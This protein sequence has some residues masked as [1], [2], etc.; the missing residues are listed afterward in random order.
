MPKETAVYTHGHHES[1]LRSH[2]WRTAANSAAYLLPELRSGQDV[3]DVGCGP[4]TITADLA[5]LV[6]PGTV[7]AVDTAEDVLDKARGAAEAAG[8]DSVRF[9]VADVHDLDFPDDSF[10]VVHAHQVLQHVG[11]PVRALRELRRVCRPGGVI[12]ARDADFGAFAWFPAVPVLDDWREVYRRVARANGGE[13]DAGRRLLSWARGAGFTDAAIT[14][15]ATTWCFATPEERAWWSGLWA[16]RTTASGYA[17]L[18]V[19]GGH[20]TAGRLAEF[21]GAWRAWG[22]AEDAWFM[23]PHGE[24]LC[25]V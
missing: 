3:L 15:T 16:D 10:D 21:A 11:D 6:A 5:A 14:A 22:A 9:A 20:A 18:A 1:V 17:G 23:V 4:G 7:T 2:T 24:I 13:P 8:V 25:R 19:D 12:A